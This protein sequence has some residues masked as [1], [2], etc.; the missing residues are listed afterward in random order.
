MA[1]LGTKGDYPIQ[2]T[3]AATAA[4][5]SNLDR[6]VGPGLDGYGAGGPGSG[7]F[8]P[9]TNNAHRIDRYE[10]AKRYPYGNGGAADNQLAGVTT[11]GYI[12][13]FYYGDHNRNGDPGLVELEWV[14]S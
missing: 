11:N 14:E 4:N 6:Y 10:V 5:W 8:N 13:F 1:K 12:N 2:A 3:T 7:F 9:V